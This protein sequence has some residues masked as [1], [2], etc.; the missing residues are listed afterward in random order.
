[1]PIELAQDLLLALPQRL[2]GGARR[3]LLT[4]RIYRKFGLQALAG[5]PV[6]PSLA[7]LAPDE[8]RGKGEALARR[9]GGL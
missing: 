3:D 9:L 1:M 6:Y 4:C 7:A 8:A 2:N 5:Q